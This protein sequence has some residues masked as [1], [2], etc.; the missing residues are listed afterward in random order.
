MNVN[1]YIKPKRFGHLIINDVFKNYRMA[2]ISIGAVFGTLLVIYLLSAIDNENQYFH[3]VS[4]PLLLFIGGFILSSLSFG[5]LHHPQKNYVYLTLPA[6]TLEKFLSKLVISTIGFIAVS[7]LLFFCFSAIA[8]WVSNLIF[9]HAGP[10][11]NP[12]DPVILL[13]MK[14]YLITQSIFLFG[15]VYFRSHAFI[16]TILILFALSMI[17]SIYSGVLG[18]LVFAKFF[19]GWHNGPAYVDFDTLPAFQSWADNFF[20]KV[21]KVFEFLFWYLLAPFF[22]V[23]SYL[24]LRETEV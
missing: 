19:D 3:L 23:L 17:I 13:N 12:F 2:L 1:S 11:F 9:N 22:W 18:R 10:L 20:I 15:A 5:E 8:A 16:K 21:G 14:I 6:A 7:S 24:R 4:Y